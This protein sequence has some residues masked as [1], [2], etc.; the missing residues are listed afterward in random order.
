MKDMC[1]ID[2]DVNNIGLS[3]NAGGENALSGLYI[4]KAL[5]ERFHLGLVERPT[6]NDHET[7]IKK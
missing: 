7:K 2:V 5:K 3:T 6:L 1:G 4:H